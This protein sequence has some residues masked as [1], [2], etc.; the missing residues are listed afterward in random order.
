MEFRHDVVAHIQAS[1]RRQHEKAVGYSGQSVLRQIDFVGVQ[2]CLQRRRDVQ[3]AP[4]SVADLQTPQG[5]QRRQLP[6]LVIGH[7]I[8]VED[9]SL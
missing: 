9:Q 4:L 2:Q 8:A 6:H 5:R 7:R 3:D 1:Q